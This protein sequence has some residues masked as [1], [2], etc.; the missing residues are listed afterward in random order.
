M[1]FSDAR[2]F[3]DLR[4]TC[5]VENQMKREL[6]AKNDFDYASKLQQNGYAIFE[7]TRKVPVINVKDYKDR[8]TIN[9]P[10]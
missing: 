5:D 1:N 2:W 10:N 9:R 8:V 3:S 7:K 4:P 6:G